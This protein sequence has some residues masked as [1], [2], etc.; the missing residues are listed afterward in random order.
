MTEETT[1]KKKGLSTLAWIGIGC[2]VL[3]VMVAAALLVI[4]MIAA[5]KF[6]DVAG[7]FKDNPEMA[8]ARLIVKMNPELEEV[9]ADEQA[10]TITVRHTKTGEIVTVSIQDLKEGRI[11]FTTD[12]GEVSVEAT[13]DG[14]EG[15][16]SVTRGDETWKMRTGVDTVGDIP[17]WVP[18]LPG[19]EAESPHVVESEGKTSGGFQLRGRGGHVPFRLNQFRMRLGKR[20]EHFALFLERALLRR[21]AFRFRRRGRLR[22]EAQLF[23]PGRHG[24]HIQQERDRLLGRRSQSEDNGEVLH[25]H[26]QFRRVGRERLFR[27]LHQRNGCGFV[28][29]L[30]PAGRFGHGFCGTEETFL[31][32]CL[33]KQVAKRSC[34]RR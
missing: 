28:A 14:E 10:G 6:K 15:T 18:V 20:D 27:L 22:L 21:Q 26:K 13:G 31:P 19:S 9:S 33:V 23:L 12:E 30:K 8:A 17:A 25:Q 32:R 1:A 5:K 16:F 29:G 24:Q 4:G 2:G 3:V 7:D 11:K 34:P